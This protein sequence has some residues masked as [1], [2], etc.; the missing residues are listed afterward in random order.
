MEIAIKGEHY[1]FMK[2]YPGFIEQAKLESNKG[3]EAV[4]DYAN[5]VEK[6]HHALYQKARG[7]IEGGKQLE[8]E[9]YFVCPVCGNTVAGEVPE[10]CPICGAAR[11]QFKRVE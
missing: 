11:S 7:A 4:F 6:I 3:A 10:K 5:N 2:M 8:A 9:P 1:E